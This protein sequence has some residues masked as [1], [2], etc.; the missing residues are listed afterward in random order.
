MLLGLGGVLVLGVCACTHTCEYGCMCLSIHIWTAEVFIRHPF[1]LL[2]TLFFKTVSLTQ[3]RIYQLASLAFIYLLCGQ[4]CIAF[5]WHSLL[6]SLEEIL[7]PPQTICNDPCLGSSLPGLRNKILEMPTS[8]SDYQNS[9]TAAAKAA[10]HAHCTMCSAHSFLFPNTSGY[11]NLAIL[12]NRTA[13][14]L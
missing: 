3:P 1:L 6:P 2:S 8:P 7:M 4:G 5:Y 10:I 9:G 13:V 11:S 12:P 14:G